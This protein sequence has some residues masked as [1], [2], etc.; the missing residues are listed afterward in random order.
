MSVRHSPALKAALFV[1][2]LIK[3]FAFSSIVMNARGNTMNIGEMGSG[4][5]GRSCRVDFVAVLHVIG[6]IGRFV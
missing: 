5:S 3:C 4:S 2:Q 1:A 6:T